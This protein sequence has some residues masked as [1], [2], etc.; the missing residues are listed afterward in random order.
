MLGVPFS[1]SPWNPRAQAAYQSQWESPRFDWEKIFRR[2]TDPD[3]LDMAVWAG[4]DRLA[5]LALAVTTGSSLNLLFLEG[6]ARNDCPLRGRRA[7]IALDVAANY[8]QAR[9][10]RELRVWPLNQRLEELYRDIYGFTL[11]VDQTNKPYWRKEV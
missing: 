9:G 3:R 6:D 5:A 2:Y 4:E 1:L 8:A 7:L 10:K 11:A